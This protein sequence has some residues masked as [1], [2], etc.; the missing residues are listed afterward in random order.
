M[1]ENTYK[2]HQ[3]ILGAIFIAYGVINLIGGITLLATLNIV[4]IFVD[5]PEVIQIVAIFSRLLGGI[6]VA[7]S[8]P[9]IIAG[10]GYLQERKWSKNIGLVIGIIYLLFIPIGTVIGIYSIW[11]S[12]Q[13]VIKEKQPVYATDLLKNANA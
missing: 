2:T 1:R 13:P 4:N 6:L 5:E 11:L 8:I 10:I 3:K 12:S 9:A 7:T